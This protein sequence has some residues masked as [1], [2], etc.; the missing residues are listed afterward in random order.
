[1]TVQPYRVDLSIATP[2]EIEY[3]AH[4]LMAV[5]EGFLSTGNPALLMPRPLILDSWQRCRGWQVSPFR[6]YAPLAVARET[7]LYQLREENALLIQAALPVIRHL[8]DFFADSGYAVV[9]SDAR[10]C[11]LE[12]VGD[13]TVRRHLARIDFVPGGDWSEHAAGTNAIGTALVDGH[14]VQ[15]MAAEHYCDGWQDLTCT[16]APIR[17]PL[18]REII[19]ILDVTGNYRLIRPFL[20]SFLVASAIEIQQRYQALLSSR[21][22]DEWQRYHFV[23]KCSDVITPLKLDLRETNVLS[24]DGIKLPVRPTNSEIRATPAFSDSHVSHAERLATAASIV[25]ASLDLNVTL[26]KVAEQAA[27]LLP[28]ERAGV[29]LFDEQGAILAMHVLST[30]QPARLERPQTLAALIKDAE[31]IALVRERGE[32]VAI[33]D[34]LTSTLFPAVLIEQMAIRSI[35]LLPLVSPRGVSGF[36]AASRSLP[37][38]WS[39]EEIRLGLTFA[40]QAAT[41][42]ENARLFSA[43]QQH[44]HQVEA[45]NAIAQLLSVLPDPGQHLDLLLQRL[46]VLLCLEAGLILL[47]DQESD[48]LSLAAHYHLN[49]GLQTDLESFPLKALSLLARRVISR[50]EPLMICAEQCEE[51]TICKALRLTGFSTVMVVPLTAGHAVLGVLFIGTRDRNGSIREDLKFFSTVGQQLGLALR[52]AQLLRSASEMEALRQ[53]DR[54][55][56]SFLAAISHDLRS[57]LTAIRASIESLL[58][59]AGTQTEPGKEH[60]LHNIAGQVHR[61]GQLVDQ[62]LDLSLIEAGGL[63]LDCDWTDLAACITDTARKFER[64]HS[65]CRIE[66]VFD[67]DLPLHY[68]DPDRLLQVLWNLLENAFKYAPGSV[69]ILV[70]AHLMEQEK[71]VLISVADRG[72]GIPEGEHERIFQR[73]YRLD[74]D[75]QARTPGSGLGLAICRGIVEAHGGRIWV[76]NHEEGGSIFC[77]ALPL[78]APEPI[79]LDTSET[80]AL[81]A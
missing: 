28:I 47:L 49:E 43:L 9:L 6:R 24:Q 34:T 69:P 73:F 71:E 19:G 78:P 45:L 56:S 79:G 11:L 21:L 32:L 57:P 38:H 58:D 54:L 40:T 12:V 46:T 27:H 59:T 20:T 48:Q 42:I 25:N 60:L 26:E 51:Q 14:V 3:T 31:A 62:L 13:A 5:R 77:V 68:I 61:L 8:I 37:H 16:A 64:L 29:Y 17:H 41:A 30:Q 76:E 53:A 18:T 15:L 72:P 75:R 23:M 52:N 22:R 7:Q 2:S 10:G 65:G 66:L 80:Q 55:K 33:D 63:V 4:R 44:N 81:L 50:Q 67:P 36:I 35:M 39:I 70:K 1:M 74:R